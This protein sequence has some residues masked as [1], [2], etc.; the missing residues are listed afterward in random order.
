MHSR[1]VFAGVT[2]IMA[3]NL[4]GC[5]STWDVA[6]S[7]LC[8]LDGFRTGDE[9]SLPTRDN[10]QVSFTS[11]SQIYFRGIDGQETQLQFGAIDFRNYYFVGERK[12]DGAKLQVDLSRVAE[13]KVKN[14]SVPSTVLVTTGILLGAVVGIGG[15]ALLAAYLGSASSGRP[16]RVADASAPV[17]APLLL[18]RVAQRRPEPFH[19]QCADATTRAHILAHWA[20]E[21]SAE[22]ASIPAFLALARDLRRASAPTNLVQAA[23]RSAREEATHTRLCLELAN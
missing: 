4:T 22:C 7:T 8:R 2:L 19:A 13:V 17:R 15:P 6:P 1:P 9:R 14:V 10:E 16:L 12:N 5:Y 23:L 21:A 18:D 11:D 20:N 3:T